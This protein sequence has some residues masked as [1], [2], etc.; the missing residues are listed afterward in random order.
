M[1]REYC[2]SAENIDVQALFLIES[3]VG[4]S[5]HWIVDVINMSHFEKYKDSTGNEDIMLRI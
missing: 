5:W 4:D 3:S 2:E 1:I